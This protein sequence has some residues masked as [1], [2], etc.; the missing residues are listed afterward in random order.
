MTWRT[1]WRAIGSLSLAATLLI[2]SW[3]FGPRIARAA[4][5]FT[6]NPAS[7][8]PG[9]TIAIVPDPGF[10]SQPPGTQFYAFYF[11]ECAGSQGSTSAPVAVGADGKVPTILLP[12]AA[13]EPAP[14]Q[15]I[16]ITVFSVTD[17]N[18]AV[19]YPLLSFDLTGGGGAAT[20]T[21]PP[22][23]TGSFGAAATATATVSATV[24]AT[25]IAQFS[26]VPGTA[27]LGQTV[28]FSA[29]GFSGNE[30][31]SLSVN[32]NGVTVTPAGG[33]YTAS[34]GTVSGSFSLP[35]S[36]QT[37]IANGAGGNA[38]YSAPVQ[39]T[40]TTSGRVLR[41]TLAVPATSVRVVSTSV[42]AG[43]AFTVQGAGFQ[44][45]EPVQITLTGPGGAATTL[46][47][48]LTAAGDGTISGSLTAP[49]VA[50]S[51]TLRATGT[52]SNLSAS[53]AL[54]LAQSGAALA[55]APIIASPGQTVAITGT[56]F[57]PN[58]TVSLSG[59]GSGPVTVQTDA[60]GSFSVSLALP[61][62]PTGPT[63]AVQATGTNNLTASALITIDNGQPAT[64]AVSPTSAAPGQTVTVV[65]ANFAAGE[66]V[67]LTLAALGA[68]GAPIAGSAQPTTA[69]AARVFTAGYT[70]PT[71]P[72]GTYLLVATGQSS[73][74]RV[75]TQ[76]SVL[77]AA[78]STP[79]SAGTV[80]FASATPYTGA[81]STST[82]AA[83]VPAATATVVAPTETTY[84]A[85]GYTGLARTNG[86]ATFRETLNLFNTTAAASAA[87]VTYY[88]GTGGRGATTRITRVVRLGPFVA[89]SLSVNGDAGNDR[90][91]SI[92]LG[93]APGV[94]AQVV[95]ARTGAAGRTLDT[96]A[97]PGS[98]KAS[99]VWHFAEGYAGEAFQEYLSLFNPNPT[100]ATIGVRFL[101]TSGTPPPPVS[102]TVP[103][104]GRLSV[105]VRSAY[106]RLA[107]PHAPKSIALLVGS[108]QP[109]AADRVLY[110][111]D[112]AGSGKFGYEVAP[113]VAAG[114]GSLVFPGLLRTGANEPYI[115]V[116]NPGDARAYLQIV[117][118]SATNHVLVSY[119]ATVAPQARL[120]VPVR[121]VLPSFSG[122]VS[123]TLN[124]TA[125]VV[126]EAPLY[127]GGSPN[128]G[129][130]P[131][132]DVLGYEGSAVSAIAG[133]DGR[134]ASIYLF[135]PG[136]TPLTVNGTV[137]TP[138]GRGTQI[139]IVVPSL[140]V[141]VYRLPQ[142]AGPRGLL[143]SAL[144]PFTAVAINGSGRPAAWGG[145]LLPPQ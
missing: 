116:L 48:T 21:P 87:T 32:I 144:R 120:T 133:L 82:P 134:D 35:V 5:A 97:S 15:F 9:T 85:E 140:G 70:V 27:A 78:T 93:H 105:N 118:R 122:I 102:Y 26:L 25:P 80:A 72:A 40:G 10:A 130:H 8:P 47:P 136:A 20:A 23:A 7:G 69:G 44:A 75:F 43:G 117:F 108:D 101:P 127:F 39:L 6:L 89:T 91:V 13:D 90:L 59:L 81:A 109:I 60:A 3:P 111:G 22:S 45:N 37:V 83:T 138:G 28:T 56:G 77:A 17:N 55:I 110:W 103:A 142:A 126:A 42:G 33:P 1:L 12:I 114:S 104:G 115:T 2:V 67:T 139:S 132:I 123:A 41:A 76:F 52:Q 137:G 49:G 128:R 62:N 30:P 19:T 99:T 11:D 4:D 129:S 38:G 57:A 106:L 66:G 50:G 94:T 29:S 51:Y 36:S 125:P 141:G 64:V 131:G 92:A 63:I 71:V 79:T 113:G 16:D 61:A 88:V 53:T 14:C 124:A 112:G 98:P 86:R 145:A 119:T 96:A 143:L 24:S 84:F 100:V 73:N 31:V 135:N 34:S 68:P 74:R 18:P 58:S 46:A 121:T 54:T 107:G 65:G 95:I